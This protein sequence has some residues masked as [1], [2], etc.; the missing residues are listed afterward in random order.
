MVITDSIASTQEMARCPN[1][2]RITIAPLLG[3]AIER[4]SNEKSVSSLFD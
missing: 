4:I 1:I 3:D 2:R